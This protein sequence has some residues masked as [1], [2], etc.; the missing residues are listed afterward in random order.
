MK[1]TYETCFLSELYNVK[2]AISEVL[3][4]FQIN[5]PQIKSEGLYE[6]R[7]IFSELLCNAVIHGNKQDISKKVK[8]EVEI[9]DDV[10]NAS[11]M[12]EGPGFDYVSLLIKASTTENIGDDHGRGIYLVY[13]L[14][15]SLSFNMQGNQI[16]FNK[17]MRIDG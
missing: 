6:L 8:V 16:R 13:S 1:H 4:F 15:D 14:T 5:M 11:I 10:I 2:T 12:D 7:L 9:T 3:R 17:R